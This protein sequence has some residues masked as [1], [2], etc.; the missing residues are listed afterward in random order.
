MRRKTVEH[1]WY[2]YLFS[3][4]NKGLQ[5][6]DLMFIWQLKVFKNSSRVQ[7]IGITVYLLPQPRLNA[8]YTSPTTLGLLYY[9]S[10]IYTHILPKTGNKI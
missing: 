1:Q 8:G 4:T 7:K 2:G 5:G 3:T 10:K 6:L 9:E